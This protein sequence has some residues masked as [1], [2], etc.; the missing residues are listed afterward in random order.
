MP[1]SG[2]APGAG[3][4]G[5]RRA[6]A[7]A[8][9]AARGPAGSP[10]AAGA[11]PRVPALSCCGAGVGRAA[12]C[13]AWAAGGC[14]SG[15]SPSSPAA[16]RTEHVTRGKRA[17]CR[18]RCGERTVLW[19]RARCPATPCP[20]CFPQSSQGCPPRGLCSDLPFGCHGR[21]ELSA[22]Q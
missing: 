6:G 10:R 1:P 20:P 7:R 4:G 2:A 19:G 12:G 18:G 16:M 17:A 8:A 22:G 14:G 15:T 21:G 3:A 11:P 13:A 5:W 9:L